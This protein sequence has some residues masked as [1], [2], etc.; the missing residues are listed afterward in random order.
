MFISGCKTLHARYDPALPKVFD[1]EIK[2]KIESHKR[3]IQVELQRYDD[4]RIENAYLEH[5]RK[6]KRTVEKDYLYVKGAVKILTNR[7][8]SGAMVMTAFM[9]A[10]GQVVAKEYGEVI[11][12]IIRLNG[13]KK[14][15]FTIK[16]SYNPDIT[17]CKISL[18]RGV[19]VSSF[20]ELE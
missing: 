8:L 7:H 13:A 6:K 19:Q 16:T 12:R 15:Y 18:G 1:A 11:P 4:A 3:T 14:G 5:K 2:T 10:E 20:R 9:N 17:N